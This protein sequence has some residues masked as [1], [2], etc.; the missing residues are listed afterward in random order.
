[1]TTILSTLSTLIEVIASSDR[2]I[3]VN[4]INHWSVI[5]CMSEWIWT[6]A[7]VASTALS[8]CATSISIIQSVDCIWVVFTASQHWTRSRARTQLISPSKRLQ[9]ALRSGFASPVLLCS[10]FLRWQSCLSSLSLLSSRSTLS[11]L[12]CL[13]FLSCWFHWIRH[14][15]STR[16]YLFGN[17]FLDFRL[18][19]ERG[20]KF[21]SRA[22]FMHRKTSRLLAAIL[23]IFDEN[24]FY[25]LLKTRIKR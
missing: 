4:R 13:F 23:K 9:P 15:L 17:Y 16:L 19:G 14:T 8:V 3:A 24:S 11:R 2:D 12:F 7:S 6:R 25:S 22:I 1:M 20:I 10:H 21:K 5:T 18:N